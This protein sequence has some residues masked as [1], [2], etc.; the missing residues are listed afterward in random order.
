[1][2]VAHSRAVRSVEGRPRSRS[3][4]TA[5]TCMIVQGWQGRSGT[6]YANS[7]ELLGQEGLLPKPKAAKPE[8]DKKA[9][10]DKKPEADKKAEGDKKPADKKPEGDKKAE[11]DKKP[12]A[13]RSRPTRSK[14]LERIA[15]VEERSST[16]FVL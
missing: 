13:T 1:M 2:T 15:Q 11:G 8:G 7:I 16:C 4:C 9:A 14:R 3:R 10:G 6:S 12:K 5:S